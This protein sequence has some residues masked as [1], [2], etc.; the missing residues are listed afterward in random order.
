MYNTL[1]FANQ[2]RYHHR[3]YSAAMKPLA[4]IGSLV[5]DAMKPPAGIGSLVGGRSRLLDAGVVAGGRSRLLDAGVVAGAMRPR[6]KRRSAGAG[7]VALRFPTSQPTVTVRPPRRV[8][9][10]EEL[11]WSELEDGHV[12]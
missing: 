6:G 5:A 4:G 7:S 3:Q 11:H 9:R 10:R 2:N 12:D 1:S 8:N